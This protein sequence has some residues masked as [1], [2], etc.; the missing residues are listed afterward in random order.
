MF[1]RRVIL[2][3]LALAIM[4]GV[5]IFLGVLLPRVLGLGS[6]T[7]MYN[8]ATLLRQVQTLSQLVTVQYVMEKVVVAEDV[9]WFGEN[10]VLMVAHGIVKAG[11]DLS[12]LEA[13]DL[14]VSGKAIVIKLPPPQ[15]TDTY[16]DD[17]ETRIIERST[18]LLRAFDKDLEQSVRQNAVAD[19]NRAARN[20]GILKDAETRAR[21][22]LTNLFRQMGF[23]KVEFAH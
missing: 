15:I 10:R 7:R 9:K 16:L 8:T 12:R 2:V 20:G 23:E 4:F 19:I 3:V 6:G 5:G 18:G 1:K 17:K 22:Q 21:A 14:K 13:G 11:I